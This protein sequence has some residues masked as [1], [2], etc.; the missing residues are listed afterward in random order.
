MLFPLIMTIGQLKNFA[1]DVV[2][3]GLFGDEQALA[4]KTLRYSQ[5]SAKCW[6]SFKE[7]IV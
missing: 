7:N 6:I 4:N 3:L 1:D 2:E 5:T